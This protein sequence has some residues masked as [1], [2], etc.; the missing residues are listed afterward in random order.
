MGTAARFS[1]SAR[2]GF[3]RRHVT[4]QPRT[5]G[6]AISR[7]QGPVSP[8]LEGEDVDTTHPEDARHWIHI[9]TE[10]LSFTDQILGR[11]RRDS[12]RM[13]PESREKIVVDI[14]GLRRQRQRYS[15]HLD[16]WYD[17][18][19][20]I[21]GFSLDANT[22]T[23]HN[24][25]RQATLTPREFQLV[26]YLAAHPGDF[27]SSTTLIAEAWHKRRLSSEQV[28]GYIRQLRAKL[29]ELELPYE[30]VN[31]PGRGYALVAMDREAGGD[32]EAIPAG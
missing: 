24:R 13:S 32:R 3:P 23:I 27:T 28:R 11:A 21:G 15:D 22:R 7:G 8:L 20:R 10:L 9:Y 29:A 14:E 16:F 19:W 25:G 6:F 30:I 4:E 18:Q 31:Q 17:R 2:A 1:G 5:A 26:S 12:A